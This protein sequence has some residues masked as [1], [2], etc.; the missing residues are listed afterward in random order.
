[1]NKIWS[2][3]T[4]IQEKY[5]CNILASTSLCLC[6]FGATY[7]LT[8]EYVP[9]NDYYMF[10]MP[11]RSLQ[12][13]KYHRSPPIHWSHVS[14][15]DHTIWQ[16]L[17]W[18]LPSLRLQISYDQLIIIDFIFYM[19]NLTQV[20]LFLLSYDANSS[21]VLLPHVILPLIKIHYFLTMN[22]YQR[23]SPCHLPRSCLSGRPTCQLLLSVPPLPV[24]LWGN[25]RSYPYIRGRALLRFD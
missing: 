9:C 21:T 7:N 20:K 19:Y 3:Y 15:N 17:A 18:T 25:P 23:Q 16:T 22:Y 13:F 24:P 12:L 11:K 6:I 10:K 5:I 2:V 1:M 8:N 14:W 4:N